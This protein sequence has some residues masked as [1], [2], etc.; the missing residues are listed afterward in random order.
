M[1]AGRPPPEPTLEMAVSPSEA[2]K[3]PV[4]SAIEIARFEASADASPVSPAPPKS[5][6]QVIALPALEPAKTPDA[7]I[8]LVALTTS[9]PTEPETEASATTE[10]VLAMLEPVASPLPDAPA[11]AAG[12]TD[13][14][15]DIT[16]T[17]QL[18][19]ITA[20]DVMEPLV[21]AIAAAAIGGQPPA[22][23]ALQP[24]AS[25]PSDA[26]QATIRT[27]W[28]ATPV[29]ALAM[30][31]SPLARGNVG[32]AIAPPE[33]ETVGFSD[34]GAPIEALPTATDLGPQEP[35]EDGLGQLPGV[36]GAPADASA[37]QAAVE[38][39][40]PEHPFGEEP[41][42]PAA[43][44]DDALEAVTE[45]SSS[46][47]A[48]AP[49]K[50]IADASMPAGDSEVPEAI[51]EIA[52]RPSDEPRSEREAQELRAERPLG[53]PSGIGRSASGD[54][55][56]GV[57]TGATD[58][59]SGGA[60]P[61][62][63]V[64]P[65][66]SVTE[67]AT[68]EETS[69]QEMP[70]ALPTMRNRRL[71]RR[72]ALEAAL[73]VNGTP[74]RLLDLSMSG[75]GA[76]NAPTLTQNSVASVSIRLSIDG[77]D[78]STRMQARIVY[79]SAPRTGG[80]F[81]DLTASQTAFLRCVVTWRGQAVGALGTTTLLDA[82][83]RSPVQGQTPLLEPPGSAEIRRPWWSRWFSRFVGRR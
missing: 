56:S 1:D 17:R 41:A 44:D 70:D 22:T 40:A 32:R 30:P 34:V 16:T 67:S 53:A 69:L 60:L 80:R 31:D 18:E 46:V 72:T 68:E 71:Y 49:A 76:A 63:L 24:S 50:A 36:S 35:A 6:P 12:R 64:E 58:V 57:D 74:A 20:L 59:P 15:F 4:E 37:E 26:D 28:F 11:E 73:D 25:S 51:A 19:P 8:P 43:G 7:I 38:S 14:D 52:T 5:A 75:F 21:E 48:D 39:P 54:A 55:A 10:H 82:I 81:V 2:A 29:F 65:Q 61:P 83:T 66:P 3:A 78:I 79:S 23:M 77:V 42:G 9:T 33:P 62:I 27:F 45:G 47:E 13:G